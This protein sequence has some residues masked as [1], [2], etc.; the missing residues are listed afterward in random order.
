MICVI[1]RHYIVETNYGLRALFVFLKLMFEI[2]KTTAQL[3]HQL[4]VLY[5]KKK[6]S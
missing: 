5:L 1:F 2:K 4:H 6:L 3:N